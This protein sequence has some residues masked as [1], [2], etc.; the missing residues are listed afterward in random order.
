MTHKASLLVILGPT[1]SGKT[2]LATSLARHLNGEIIS[3]DSRQ[4]YRTMDIGTGK[5]LEQYGNIVYHLIDIRDPGESYDVAQYREDFEIAMQG[6]LTKQKQPILCGGSGLYLQAVLQ[7]FNQIRIPQDPQL[8]K[9]LETWDDRSLRAY[10]QNIKSKALYKHAIDTRKR[11]IRAIEM[12]KWLEK[13]SLEEKRSIDYVPYVVGLNPDL[14]IRRARISERLQMRLQTGLVPEVEQLLNAGVHE[15]QLIAYG[16]EYK[17]AC[18]Y[19][20]G[21]ITF[22]LF[23][24]KLETEIHRFAK[25]QMTY[26]RKMEKDGIKIHWLQSQTLAGLTEEVLKKQNEFL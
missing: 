5:D 22:Q 26:F 20:S 14:H 9:E 16:L 13:H 10:F 11:L 25:R 3:A 17:W 7:D 24:K 8:R 4:V 15:N 23:V 19:L 1:A 18:M 6:I 21:K 12:G 2:A